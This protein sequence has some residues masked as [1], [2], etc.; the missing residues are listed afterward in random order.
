M[1]AAPRGPGCG[2]ERVQ[3]LQLETESAWSSHCFQKNKSTALQVINISWAS[4]QLL[5]KTVGLLCPQEAVQFHTRPYLGGRYTR[6]FVPA[7]TS[8]PAGTIWIWDLD[9]IQENL[10]IYVCFWQEFGCPPTLGGILG[11]N[12]WV[13][14]MT[15]PASLNE[16]FG[17]GTS[18]SK[19]GYPILQMSNR[20]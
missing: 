13:C 4:F 12:W 17:I 20:W 15:S 18:V 2:Q 16:S 9:G 6:V 3:E 1:F 14:M 19:T 11:I 5:G 8:T 10:G 7:F